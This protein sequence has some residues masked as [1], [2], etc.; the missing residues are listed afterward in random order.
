MRKSRL[1]KQRNEQKNEGIEAEA[2][3][4]ADELEVPAKTKLY[5]KIFVGTLI[6]ITTAVF[7]G[8]DMINKQ[9]DKALLAR[10]VEEDKEN[11]AAQ[12]EK[13]METDVAEIR[14]LKVQADAAYQAS[15]YF[16]T[17][18]FYKQ[19][20]NIDEA[21]IEVHEK[22]IAAL[23]ASCENGHDLHCDAIEKAEKRLKIVEN[24]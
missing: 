11:Q 12:K 8:T 16:A 21:D 6:L 15:D 9:D 14:D 2:N 13:T 1:N 18:F 24:E 7:I 17:V 5:I 22:L 20:L 3:P 4:Y 23:K 19:I 10:I